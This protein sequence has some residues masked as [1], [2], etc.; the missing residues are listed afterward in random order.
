MPGPFTG[1]D[2]CIE[3]QA[4]WPDFHNALIAQIRNELG[5][6]L[7]ECYIARIGESTMPRPLP[8]NGPLHRSPGRMAKLP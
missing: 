3:V 1:M 6:R 4:R 8:R 2:P 7:P 5:A